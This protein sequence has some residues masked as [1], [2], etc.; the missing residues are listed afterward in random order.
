V[1]LT[2]HKN[3]GD[4]LAAV[5]DHSRLWYFTKFA[6]KS[7]YEASF[8]P[9]DSLVFGKETTGLPDAVRQI[10]PE[11][12]QLRVPMP[13]QEIVRSL[14]LAGTAHIALYEALRQVDFRV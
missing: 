6:Q 14:N 9:G 5:P 13:G 8:Q 4:Y 3:Y 11:A 7:L 10:A 2:V 12:Q 1:Q